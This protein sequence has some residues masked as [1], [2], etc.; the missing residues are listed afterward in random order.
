MKKSNYRMGFLYFM[1]SVFYS[2]N[3]GAQQC[4]RLFSEPDP[5]SL[6][7]LIFASVKNSTLN[8]GYMLTET[9]SQ[10]NSTQSNHERNGIITNIV[11]LNN[12]ALQLFD[13]IRANQTL[14]SSYKGQMMQN[15]LI[16]ALLKLFKR[17]GF[18][19]DLIKL[20]VDSRKELNNK[21][22]EEDKKVPQQIGFIRQSLTT[23]A[24]PSHRTLGFGRKEL[25]AELYGRKSNDSEGPRDDSTET[26]KNPIGFIHSKDRTAQSKPLK[27]IGFV[28]SDEPLD[29][30]YTVSLGFDFNNSTFVAVSNQRPVGFR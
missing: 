25:E 7:Q 15:T 6:S 9:Y 10:L 2:I 24:E 21:L 23:P 12:S 1:V 27:F 20:I 14:N 30:A 11:G 18:A 16:D 29:V 4:I 28:Q 13:A 19:R 3:V 5:P 8:L 22:L 26:V 17:Q